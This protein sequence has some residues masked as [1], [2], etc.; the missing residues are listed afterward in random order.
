MIDRNP[1]S[2]YPRLVTI[3]IIAIAA[4]AFMVAA[5]V[6]SAGLLQ[7]GVI[8]ATDGVPCEWSFEGTGAGP[9]PDGL[10]GTNP[11]L[12]GSPLNVSF[13]VSG[14]TGDVIDVAVR[15]TAAHRWIGDVDAVLSAPNGGPSMVI[16]GH[17][18]AQS[19]TLFGDSSNLGGTYTFSDAAAVDIWSAAAGLGGSPPCGD[20]CV[21]PSG[22]Y[23]TTERGGPG[24]T[25]PA[26]VT[27]L[28]A[29]FATLTPD[30]TNGIWTLTI[31][32]GAAAERG[33]ITAATLLL[34]TGGQCAPLTPTPTPTP[35][36]TPTP[37]ATPGIVT[38][39]L[40]TAPAGLSYMVDFQL[41]NT[42][43][44][45]TWLRGS[46]HL[47]AAVSP[48]GSGEDERYVWD[49]WSDGGE[50]THEIQAFGGTYIVQY[51]KQYLL[52]MAAASGTVS[53]ETG[54][55]DLGESVRIF[56]E[57]GPPGLNVTWTGGG[58]GSYTGVNNPATVV[59]LGPITESAVWVD[60]TPTPSPTASP[61]PGVVPVTVQTEPTGRPFT[62]DGVSYSTPQTFDW[63]E[64]STHTI[65]TTLIDGGDSTRYIFDNWSDGGTLT[66]N[67]IAS[68]STPSYTATFRTQYWLDVCC[69]SGPFRVQPES[70]FREAG[71]TV[72]IYAGGGNFEMTG[73]SGTGNGSYTGPQSS[74]V[75]A[76]NGPINEYASFGTLP[77]PK[78]I[79][80][81][82]SDQ[83]TDIS[84]FRPS[85][86][87]WYVNRSS[88]EPYIRQFG[89]ETD[90]LAPADY[91]G[92]GKTDIAVYRPSEGNWYIARSSDGTIDV[93]NW[94]V[95]EDIPTPGDFYPL[96]GRAEIAVFRPSTGVWYMW[97]QSVQF[98]QVGDVPTVGDFDGDLRTDIGVYRPSTGIWYWKSSSG[99]YYWA[100]QFGTTGD[101]P[102]PARWE[103]GPTTQMAVF[104]PSDGTWYVRRSAT[105]YTA[106]QFGL[107]GDIP[108]PG[109][110]DADGV[111][112]YAV[113]RPSDGYWY[114]ANS[115]N[116]TF[117]VFPWGLAGD[118]PTQ[119]AFGH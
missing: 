104:R 62:V 89:L 51:K 55:F 13:A 25:A 57:G 3:V 116:G 71:Q 50:E 106:Y 4:V 14:P 73:W 87:T 32:D 10:A 58:N 15:I 79:G 75:V 34:R 67:I 20:D 8:A 78:I 11:P 100:E 92:D 105:S 7:P 28:D 83:R 1:I 22:T 111:A 76:M 119:S 2:T 114:I 113:F 97:F 72:S 12:Y 112:D 43:Q 109:Y 86:A 38:V 88:G 99:G 90:K 40:G 70:G 94:G 48:Q 16:F 101:I 33:D 23:R 42:A 117:T 54:F 5:D 115:S 63:I 47:I 29:V 35:P 18:G 91:D 36:L 6:R 74:A 19:G 102:V 49:S 69:N 46:P 77:G 27:S 93:F 31:R 98:G 68:A 56:A 17:V 30:R 41:Y 65:S 80:D 21:V 96:D 66:H 60:P 118:I 37:T 64:G 61:T 39:N 53:P 110:Y 95:A 26:P 44:T 59:M 85:D 103:H 24:Q 52:T 45:F 81:Y 107:S 84:V 108:V 9:I 82:D